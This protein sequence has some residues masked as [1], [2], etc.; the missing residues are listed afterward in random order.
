MRRKKLWFF[1]IG[2]LIVI[3]GFFIYLLLTPEPSE[4][5]WVEIGPKFE[6][7]QYYELQETEEGTFLVNKHAGFSLKVPDGWK[8]EKVNTGIDQW[9][10]NLLSPDAIL[11]NSQLQQGCGVSVW[12]EYDERSYN[13]TLANLENPKRISEYVLYQKV[14]IHG[15]SSLQLIGESEKVGKIIGSKV[16]FKQNTLLIIDTRI[17]PKRSECET[18]YNQILD[19]IN[20]L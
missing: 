13:H 2:A 16:P 11:E 14:K 17:L 7:P 3:A 15:I 19:S 1:I 5:E 10:V 9:I 18:F 6:E 12:V 8:V 20:F 4:E